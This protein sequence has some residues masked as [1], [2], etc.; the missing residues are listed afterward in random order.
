MAV[1]VI[2]VNYRT[3]EQVVGCVRSIA[4][5][6]L[7]P[8]GMKVVVIDNASGDGSVERLN[9]EIEAAG[10]SDW[11]RVVALDYNGGF[12]CG[13]NRG[14]QEA[15]S[16]AEPADH[17]LLLN[18][19]TVVRPGAVATLARCIDDNEYAG[20]VG[21]SIE[22]AIGRIEATAHRM[23]S[24]LGELERAARCGPISRVLANHV[25]CMEPAEEAHACGWVSGACMLI[26][27]DVLEQVGLL[28]EGFF[29]YFEE[30][31][32]CVRARAAGWECRYVPQA[33]IVHLEGQSTGIHAPRKRR[34]PYWFDSRRRYFLKHHGLLGLFTA[35]LCW[36]LGRTLFWVRRLC[37][38]GGDVSHDPKWLTWDILIGDMKALLGRSLSSA[39]GCHE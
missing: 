12:A 25:S 19:D 38:L 8:Q 29:L 36:A 31:D 2:I 6:D 13:N 27:R 37:G 18:P 9:A 7:S 17:V 5:D 15:L 32:F 20:I 30:V 10:W 23:L 21:A 34:P 28:D 35:D 1:C 4:A 24:P 26:R 11:A 16:R 39:R 22:N 14:I 33:R 3:A